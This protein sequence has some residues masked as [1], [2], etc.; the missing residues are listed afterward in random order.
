M[1][2]RKQQHALTPTVVFFR[3]SYEGAEP[4]QKELKKTLTRDMSFFLIEDRTIL[5]QQGRLD[6]ILD[7]C[8]GI[9]LCQST[10]FTASTSGAKV[11]LIRKPHSK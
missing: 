11:E 5:K 9:K 1:R 6:F 3:S 7:L 2:R 4:I 8:K 10:L